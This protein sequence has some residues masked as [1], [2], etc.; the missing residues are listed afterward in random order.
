MNE[1][2]CICEYEGLDTGVTLYAEDSGNGGI[3]HIRNRYCP[4][5]GKKLESRLDYN[6]HYFGC[7][8]KGVDWKDSRDEGGEH[9]DRSQ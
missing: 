1:E 9:K 7:E 5:C 2:K 8:Y 3:E 6:I 4:I